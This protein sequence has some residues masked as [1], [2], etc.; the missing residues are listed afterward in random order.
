MRLSRLTLSGFKSFADTTEFTFDAPVTAIVGPNGCGKSNVVDAIKWVL[1]ER[2]AK[3]LR[4]KEMADVIFAG[5]AGRAPGGLASV[6][7]TFENPELTEEQLARLREAAEERGT[8]SSPEP[9]S[10][11]AAELAEGIEAELGEASALLVRGGE[12]RRALPIDTETV[13]V[14]RRLYRDG[15]SHY[16]INGARARLKDIRELFLDTGVGADAYSIIEQGKVDALLL[17]NPVER[18]QFFEEA[19]GVARFKARRI[20]AQRKLERA[21]ANLVRAREQLDSTERRLRLVRGQAA[22]ARK[23]KEL[24]V[25]LRGLK[26][27][28]AF[29]QFDDLCERLTGLTSRLHDLGGERESAIALVA[30]L[31]E[32]R[33]E[34]EIARHDAITRQQALERERS[35]AEHRR[36]TAEQRRAMTLRA[37]EDAQRQ[38]AEDER[39]HNDLGSRLSTMA[40]AWSEAERERITLTAALEEAEVALR[41]VGAERETVQAALAELRVKLAERRAEVSSIDRERTGIEARVEADRRRLQALEEQAS[42]MDARAK[43]LAEEADEASR[44]VAEIDT[45]LQDRRARLSTLERESATLSASSTSVSDEQRS[46]SERLSEMEQRH[47]RIDSR[48]LTL[49]EMAESREGLGE[50]VKAVLDR[51]DRER[52][53]G[54]DG[55]FARVIGPLADAI[56]VEAQDAV[57]VEAALGPSLQAL[58]VERASD[59]ADQRL[60]G[61]LDGRVSFIPIDMGQVEHAP[62]SPEVPF[63]S[64]GRFMPMA[65]LVRTEPNLE[66]VLERLLGRTYLVTDLD[67]AMMLAAGP[68]AGLGARFV[69]RS[70][71][72]LEADGRIVAG[73]LGGAGE[74]GEGLLQRRSELALLVG[75]IAVLDAQLHS[76]RAA[77]R[78]LDERAAEIGARVAE[79][80]VAIATEQR[81]LVGEES[82]R[83]RLESDRTRLE[84]DRS[85]AIEDAREATE[86]ATGVRQEQS[87]LT[88]KAESLRRLHD[89]RVELTQQIERELE[90]HQSRLEAANE[91]L[92]SAKVEAGQRGEKLTSL[93]RELR[94]VELERDEAERQRERLREAVESRRSTLAEDHAVIQASAV[95]IESAQAQAHEAG[96]QLA[97]L[98]DEAAAQIA[99]AAQAGE[100]LN[101]ARSRCDHLNRDWNSLELTKRELE[102]RR[103]NVEERAQEDIGLDLRNEHPHYSQMM[104]DGGVARID[105]ESTAAEIEELRQTIA[106]LGNVNLDAIDEESVLESRNDELVR[107]V[108]DID[109]A[110]ARLEE[111][112]TRLNDASRDRFKTI[113][114]AI[115][116][117]FSGPSGMFRRLFGGGRAELRL[118]PVPETGEIDW[119]ESGIEVTAKPPGKEPRSI[120]QLSGGEK[121]M[122]A[123]ALLLSIF[124]SNPSPF[125]VLDEVDAAL[126]DANVERFGAIVRQFLDRCH[127][128]IITHNKRT[129]QTADQLYGVTMQERGVSKRV[130]VRFDQVGEDGRIQTA[131][132]VA[133]IDD[134]EHLHDEPPP[135]PTPAPAPEIHTRPSTPLRR[136]L[137][138]SSPNG[139]DRAS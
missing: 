93:R 78:S 31:E 5:S 34:A 75:Q 44:T 35:A 53:A 109:A 117:S 108:A 43:A 18:R 50:A 83:E 55:L 96:E 4:G 94:R 87:E 98:A 133:P 6:K 105:A 64:P 58:L 88:R 46:L 106:R 16:L 67:A 77:L 124:Q 59:I 70:G 60:L 125:C 42:R 74:A 26:A 116:S 115:Q 48:R 36:Q 114:E 89:E 76:D 134:L 22:K 30:E 113:F 28:L 137:A 45:V 79:L 130:S 47:A 127:F 101:A 119:L 139:A 65:R 68:L 52:D 66:P 57:A 29:D 131:P 20:E 14:E 112:I 118:V 51:R 17:A 49:Q 121:T 90:S 37:L 8:P 122:T 129:M 12:R 86:R 25:T 27:A 56:H 41:E 39:R 21:E 85:M 15:A 99:A 7:L 38:L 62:R 63:Y 97:L 92:T 23:F 69:T 135:S 33:Q 100:R 91:R 123:V 136:S 73:P 9:D 103:E 11:A 72:L 54:G 2:S 126:D 19:A 95:E 82:R 32:A 107:Q 84:R 102:V 132:G 81:A 111:L 110:R 61:A 3:S 1:G 104:A 128:I 138:A 71:V 120:S 24:D 10:A 13:E 80:R 40:G